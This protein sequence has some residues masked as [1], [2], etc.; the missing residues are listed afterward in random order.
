MLARAATLTAEKCIAYG[1]PVTKIFPADLLAGKRGI[2]GHVD[3]TNAWHQSDH[4]DP[5]PDFPWASFLASVRT[6]V[7]RLQGAPAMPTRAT[8]AT[9]LGRI[10]LGLLAQL[11]GADAKTVNQSRP[12][13]RAQLAVI[14]A[15]VNSL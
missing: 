6:E 1:I 3:V 10:K 4:T 8:A 5:G 2:C 15:L 11:Q 7:T 14:R 9:P 12:L 13:K